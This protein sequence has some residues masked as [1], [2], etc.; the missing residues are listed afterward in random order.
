M[1]RPERGVCFI[2]CPVVRTR[3]YVDGFNLY[4]GALR[5]TAFKWLDLD[6]LCRRLL[7][8]ENRIDHIHYFSAPVASRPSDPGKP[9]RQQL[10]FRALRTIPHLTITEGRFLSSRVRMHLAAPNPCSEPYAWVDKTE[11]KG[12]DVNL[13]SMLLVDGF[14]GLYDVAVVI[15]NDSDLELP[16][17]LVTQKLGLSVGN[18]NPHQKPSFH[19]KPW[20]TFY[21]PIRKG[22]LRDSQFPSTLRDAHGVFSKPKGW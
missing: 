6:S 21:K 10:Y 3:I 16:I 5:R 15:S 4:Y 11:E 14:D 19:L 12:S 20:L 17:R 1:R 18:L 22:V 8:P 9:Q 7:S 2:I 13:A